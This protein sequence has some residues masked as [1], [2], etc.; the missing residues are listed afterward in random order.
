MKAGEGLGD[1]VKRLKGTD[2]GGCSYRTCLGGRPN[3]FLHLFGSLRIDIQLRFSYSQLTVKRD[4][5]KISSRGTMELR[6]LSALVTGASSFIGHRLA[7]RLVSEEG[8]RVR[9]TAKVITL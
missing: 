1:V 7:E 5:I 4:P 2:I 8:V 9:K 6:R 3:T